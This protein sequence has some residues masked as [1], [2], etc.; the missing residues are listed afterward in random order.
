[1]R[2]A[3]QMKAE[4]EEPSQSGQ[5][6]N[7]DTVLDR[8]DAGR[9]RYQQRQYEGRCSENSVPQRKRHPTLRTSE[10]ADCHDEPAERS[11]QK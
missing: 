10:N 9:D 11:V 1:M 3:T 5:N 6:Q 8:S 4:E 7:G 2:F